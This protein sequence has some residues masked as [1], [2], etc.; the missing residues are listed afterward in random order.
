MVTDFTSVNLTLPKYMWS[1]FVFISKNTSTT[2]FLFALKLFLGR[3]KKLVDVG[4]EQENFQLK[5][6]KLLGF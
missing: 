1:I 3:F 6:K 5:K 2:V 4:K